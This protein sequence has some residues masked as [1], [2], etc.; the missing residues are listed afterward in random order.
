MSRQRPLNRSVHPLGSVSP[1]DPE[2]GLRAR[3]PGPLKKTA[4]FHAITEAAFKNLTFKYNQDLPLLEA[5]SGS[6]Q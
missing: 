3:L 4:A 5:K 2:R 1:G 6:G